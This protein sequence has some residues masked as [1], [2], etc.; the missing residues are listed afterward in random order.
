MFGLR[1]EKGYT[2]WVARKAPPL[3]FTISS[4]YVRLN[5]A[6]IGFIFFFLIGIVAGSQLLS[7]LKSIQSGTNILKSPKA[8]PP[9]PITATP[10]QFT[11]AP[12]V[13][14][15][16]HNITVPAIPMGNQVD[17]KLENYLITQY[18]LSTD[19]AIAITK[20]AFEIANEYGLER[21]H[22]IAIAAHT[23]K[24]HPD[25]RS[26]S[27]RVTNI[28]STK[29]QNIAF[30]IRSSGLDVNSTHGQ[31]KLLAEDLSEYYKSSNQDMN[32]AILKLLQ[33]TGMKESDLIAITNIKQY[34]D[35]LTKSN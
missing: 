19:N 7:L 10:I 30:K 34:L 6:I 1:K 4:V 2:P 22:L 11:Q 9:T 16:F 5:L 27:I 32:A 18:Q 24:Y 17:G 15:K 35:N 12:A 23:G 3:M 31:F 25:Q 20:S 13:D 33:E 29:H 14:P 8:E 28:D 26:N 21:N